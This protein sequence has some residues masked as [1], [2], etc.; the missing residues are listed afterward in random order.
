PFAVA[1][2][3]DV[4]IGRLAFALGVWFAIAAALAFARGHPRLAA[5]LAAGCAAA[6]PVAGILLALAGVTHSLVR[7]RSGSA[8]ALAAPAVAVAGARAALFPEGGTEPYPLLS[9]LATLLVVAAF[10]I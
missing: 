5:L 1:A 3:G 9:L 4:W 8:L 10:L 2:A 7:R 6:S